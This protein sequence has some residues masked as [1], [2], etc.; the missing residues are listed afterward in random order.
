[1]PDRAKFYFAGRLVHQ[2]RNAEGLEAIVQD[3]FGIRTQV[4]TFFG[5]WLDLPP[6]PPVSWVILRT[7][8]RSESP[9]SL[10]RTSGPAS[11]ISASAW[12][13]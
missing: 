1:V 6:G 10:A 4:L 11:S 9:L 13:P 7:P 8:A 3:F 5:R 2:T 12:G